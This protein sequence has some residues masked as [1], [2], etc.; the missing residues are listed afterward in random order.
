MVSTNLNGID[1]K[2]LNLLQAEFPLTVEPYAD[3]GL[4]LGIEA[5][6]VLHRIG[7]LKTEG[8]IRQISPVLDARSLGYQTTLVAMRVTGSRLDG[9]ER[10]IANH[11]GVSHGY[12]R[13]H[14]F[15]FWFTLAIPHGADMESELEQLTGP[16]GA[17]A[18]FALPA[19]KLFKLRAY[20]SMDDNG[21][22]TPDT[23]THT[24]DILP[25]KVELSRIDKTI[26]N[27]LQQDIHI[28][29]APFA[30][31]AQRAGIEIDRFLTQCH[32]LQQRG[33]M[34]RFGASINHNRA[35]FKANSM[36]CWIA[37]PDALDVAGQKLA[38][39]R[40]VSHCYGR[41]TNPL[42]QH[43]LFAMIHG[44]TK[45]ACQEIAS[46]VSGETGLTDCIMLFSTREL[47]KT[48]V[49]YLV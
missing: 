12:E 35:G 13:N 43:N 32:S 10:V 22:Y 24:G 29:P 5:D 9:A 33:I 1:R 25:Q 15:N 3:L 8:I 27:E 30:A 36:T 45:K 48:R 18:V 47:K 38:A 41:R 2:L 6:E 7:Q 44:R 16:I 19:I 39:L 17:E 40:E 42:W 4:Q 34:R 11:P 31:M 23:G 21:E 49:K 37:S 14:N 46:I 28:S 26:I 20:F